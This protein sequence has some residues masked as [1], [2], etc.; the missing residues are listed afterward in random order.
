M[1]FLIGNMMIPTLSNVNGKKHQMYN[2]S[3]Y[4]N[5]NK[6]WI[7]LPCSLSNGNMIWFM[8]RSNE[9]L[10]R[11][12]KISQEIITPKIYPKEIIGIEMI[13]FQGKIIPGN[14]EHKE[15]EDMVNMVVTTEI[16]EEVQVLKEAGKLMLVVEEDTIGM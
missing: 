4:N 6:E 5:N 11:L 2:N 8:S 3:N 7:L 13:G 1:S 12:L 14:K 15:R 10:L 9:N 16:V